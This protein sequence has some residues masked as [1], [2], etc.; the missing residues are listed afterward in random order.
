MYTWKSYFIVQ[1]DYQHWANEVM[2][3]ALGHL[4]Q[5]AIVSDQGLCGVN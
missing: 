5:E 3:T 1:A 2:F 4:D